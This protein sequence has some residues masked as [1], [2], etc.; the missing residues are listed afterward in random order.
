MLPHKVTF[1]N[2]LG[3]IDFGKSQPS[4]KKAMLGSREVPLT[5]EGS[6]SVGVQGTGILLG[7]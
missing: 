5:P 4:R 6:F 7:D 2:G 1:D 3:I